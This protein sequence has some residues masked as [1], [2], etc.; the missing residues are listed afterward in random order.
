MYLLIF[1]LPLEWKHIYIF[2]FANL[3][4]LESLQ[5]TNVRYGGYLKNPCLGFLTEDQ[6]N[7]FIYF[8]RLLCESSQVIKMKTMLNKKTATQ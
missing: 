1:Y 3:I 8:S 7:T 6:E 5:S 4:V 2:F